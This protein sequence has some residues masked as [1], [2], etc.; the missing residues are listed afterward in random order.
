[1]TDQLRNLL[2]FGPFRIDPVDHLLLREGQPVSLTI[3]AFNALLVLIQSSGHLVERPD[4]MKVLWH[5]SFVEEGNLTV[6]ISMLRKALGDDKNKCK[7][8]QT[9]PKRGYRF[10]GN[11]REIAE[12]ASELPMRTLAVLPFQNLSSNAV[13]DYL[14]LGMADAVITKLGSTG[15][16]VVRPTSAVVKY[17]DSPIDLPTVGRE[18]KVDAI[19]TG[20]IEAFPDRI[21]VTVQLVR[22][23]DAVLLWAHTFEK[24]PQYRVALEDEV[25]EGIAQSV[26]S[27][28]SGRTNKRLARRRTEN[29]K[30]YQLYMEGRYFGNKRTQEGL[31]CSIQCLEEATAEDPQYAL[32]YAALADSY[33]LLGSYEV[34]SAE[35]A[36]PRAKAAALKALELD[37]S[38]AEAHSSLG[39]TLLFYEWNWPEAE[40]EFQRAI[41]LNPNYP[42]AH[43]WYA[44]NLAVMGRLKEALDHA[45]RA[46]EMDPVSLIVN[47][48]LGRVFYLSRQYN[49]AVDVYR[50]VVVLDPQFARAHTR[51]GMTYAAM[52]AFSDAIDELEKARRLSGPDPYLRGILGYVQA[53]SGNRRAARKQIEELTQRSGC[54]YVPAYGIALISIALGDHVGALDWLAK[55]HQYRSPHLKCAKTDPLLDPVRSNP[56]FAKLLRQMRL[57]T[58]VHI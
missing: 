2:E 39:M 23:A 53:L 50:K 30:A 16:I 40:Q 45:Q 26:S 54:Q 58:S 3:K 9:I 24:D 7:Y 46:Q 10:V 1:M 13:H 18:Q 47:T 37:D 5:D 57:G 38:L 15:E 29:M 43:T 42:L 28:F 27:H 4:L 19:L 31:R 34:E 55:A 48:E 52:R 36:Y 33:A 51:L 17:S 41:A 49:R 8:I 21:R 35:Q 14:G 56:R 25:A 44:L 20:H 6:T 22:V 11:V 32:A 12:S